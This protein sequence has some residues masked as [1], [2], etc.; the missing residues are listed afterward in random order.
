MF[1]FIPES[2]NPLS[3]YD[4]EGNSILVFGNVKE[5]LRTI[6]FCSS[7]FTFSS[8]SNPNNDDSEIA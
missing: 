5:D 3:T 7:S 6:E 4:L 2:F 8:G 1:L